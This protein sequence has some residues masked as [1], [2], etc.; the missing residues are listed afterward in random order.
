L[1]LLQIAKLTNPTIGPFASPMS[2][3]SG[4]GLCWQVADKATLVT[5]EPIT[6]GISPL[7]PWNPLAPGWLPPCLHAN[8]TMSGDPDVEVS[9]VAAASMEKECSFERK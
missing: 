2:N 7:K 4:E 8:R 5:Q 6:S 1:V 3:S 9:A